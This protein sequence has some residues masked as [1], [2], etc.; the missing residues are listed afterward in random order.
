MRYQ[1]KQKEEMDRKRNELIGS[2]TTVPMLDLNE[3]NKI[4][5]GNGKVTEFIHTIFFFNLV[6][7]R[8]L[9]KKKNSMVR[10]TG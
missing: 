2:R 8:L 5:I 6:F 3:N 7:F 1:Q 4:Q 9:A 10:H